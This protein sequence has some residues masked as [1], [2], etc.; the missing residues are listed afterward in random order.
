MKLF[1]SLGPNPH[2]VR[3]FAA[4][5]G[6][7][8]PLQEI[9]VIGGEHRRPPYSTLNPMMQTPAFEADDGQI[10]VELTAICEYLEELHPNPPL[11]GATPGERAETRMWVRRL[12]LNIIEGRSRA[13]RA[14]MGRAFYIDKIKLLS[15]EAAEELRAVVEDRIVWLDG[16]VAGK[17]WICGDRFSLADIMLYCFMAFGAPESGNN[18]PA[19]TPNLAAWFDRV[20]ARP[21]AVA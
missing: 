14:T 5:K 2:T 13:G 8:L 21:S 1:N 12:D 17:T 20:K 9:D 18:L 10:I 16:Q 6:I 15:V 4:E 7:D 19:G 11:I 3:M